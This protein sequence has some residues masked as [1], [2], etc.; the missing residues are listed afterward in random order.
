MITSPKRFFFF[1]QNL[2]EIVGISQDKR[3]PG[4]HMNKSDRKVNWL[5]SNEAFNIVS[6]SL[7]YFKRI[8]T[9]TFLLLDQMEIRM[10]EE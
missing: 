5:V 9:W 4:N 1:K 8:I 10:K 2:K 6:R 7:N 3:I